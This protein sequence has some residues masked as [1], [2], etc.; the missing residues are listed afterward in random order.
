MHW[1]VPVGSLRPLLPR[2]L[3][4]DLFQGGAWLGVV[5]FR[6]SA[7]RLRCLP[8]LPFASSFPELNVRTYVRH[9]D[10]PGV[11]FFSL[12]A[13]SLVAVCTARRFFHL[14]YFHSR[15]EALREGEAYYYSCR[16][17]DEGSGIAEFRARYRPVGDIQ[18]SIP[19]S[20]EH[21]L[22]ERYCLYAADRRGGLW[23]GDIHHEPWPLQA[24]E[25]EV[26]LNTMTHPLGFKFP[27]EAPLLHFARRLDVV[28]WLIQRV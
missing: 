22:T 24:A 5:P 28:A 21:W 1:V 27:R 12:D 26:E 16:R 17:R 23:R 3:E 2:G 18:R 20:L 6:M 4:L 9:R 15:M 8:A 25:V 7:T 14:S 10:K 19:G 13:A 11:W